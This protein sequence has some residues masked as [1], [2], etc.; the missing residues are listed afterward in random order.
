MTQRERDEL[1]IEN[2]QMLKY[3]ISYL[4]HKHNDYEDFMI[5]V[6]ANIVGN[7]FI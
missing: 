7:Q 1:L 3:I 5:N 6:A 2:N 4:K